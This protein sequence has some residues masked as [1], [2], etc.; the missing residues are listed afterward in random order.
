VK[1]VAQIGAAIGRKFSFSLIAA[2][3][4][5]P[6]QELAAAL[7]RLVAAEM[8]FQRGVPPDATY[9]FKHALVQDAAYS[10]LLRGRRRT[11]Q[12]A[13]VKELIGIRTPT[14]RYCGVLGLEPRQMK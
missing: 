12:A 8:I 7:A 10:S 14:C 4:G 13:I 5:I 11:L 6:E 3:S 2:V 9:L 1:D